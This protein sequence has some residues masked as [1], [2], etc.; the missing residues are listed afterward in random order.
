MDN[1]FF[2]CQFMGGLGNQLFQAAHVLSQSYRFG[3]T[4]KFRSVSQTPNQGLQTSNYKKNIFRNLNFEENITPSVRIT[5]SN[6]SFNILNPPLDSS[7]EFNGYFQSSKNFYGYQNKI[8][9]VFSIGNTEEKYLKEKYPEL[10]DDNSVSLHVR[11]GDYS[12]FP[13]VHPIIS[14]SYITECLNQIENISKIFIFSDDKG[15]VNENLKLENSIFVN[16]EDYMELWMMSLCQNNILSNSSFSW[17]G[18]FLNKNKSKKVFV[19]SVWFGPNG[20]NNYIDI[21]ESY[22]TIIKVNVIGN[23]LEYVT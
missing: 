18:G 14:K 3:I 2:T 12:K 17:W 16:E 8:K 9:E 4:S 13:L 20:P 11:R 21:Y 6:W 15:W 22:H 5:E 1:I 23:S 7:C 19:P 10:G